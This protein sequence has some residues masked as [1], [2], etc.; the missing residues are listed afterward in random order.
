MRLYHL[1]QRPAAISAALGIPHLEVTSLSIPRLKKRGTALFSMPGAVSRTSLEEDN[2]CKVAEWLLQSAYVDTVYL[3]GDE[4]DKA[5]NLRIRAFSKSK[6]IIDKAVMSLVESFELISAARFFLGN[7]SG[8]MHISALA[9]VPTLGL[10]G[11]NFPHISGPLGTQSRWI[12]HEFPCSG[13]NQ[14]TC[15]YGY[16]CI[17]AITVEET[18]Q[19][20]K[21][22]TG[23]S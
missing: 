11:P 8:P 6:A 12:F 14:R 1:A 13:C 22:M 5:I 2:F 18:L 4:A 17:N 23:I 9:G 19:A 10:L 21:Q 16:R 20:I 3:I 7:D 15:D